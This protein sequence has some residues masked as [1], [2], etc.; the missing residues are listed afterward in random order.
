MRA[1]TAWTDCVVK[2]YSQLDLALTFADRPVDMI[3]DGIDVA[4]RIGA[5]KDD[6]ELVARRLGEQHNVICAAPDYL[7]RRGPVENR[8]A[9]LQHD[10]IIGWRRGM[11]AT[12][13]L[14]GPDERIEEQEIHVRHALEEAFRWGAA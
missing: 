10:C 8:V 13:L 3:A 9:L 12:W 4:I 7:Q 11:R 1:P 14:K 6:A 5:L 2:R